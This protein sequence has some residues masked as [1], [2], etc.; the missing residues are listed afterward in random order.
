MSDTIIK[1][2][3]NETGESSAN[4]QDESAGAQQNGQS[5][6]NRLTQEGANRIA[7]AL[8]QLN[9]IN[10]RAIIHPGDAKLKEELTKFVTNNLF[11]YADE[12]LGCFFTVRVEYEPAIVALARVLQR[13]DGVRQQWFAQQAAMEQAMQEAQQPQQPSEAGKAL[14]ESQERK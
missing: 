3:S 10:T 7:G 8:A 6:S 11:R 9:D 2:N 13:V 14:K 1:P 4:P 5:K 12:L